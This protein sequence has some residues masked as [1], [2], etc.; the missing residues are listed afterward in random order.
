L[1]W[2]MQ[3]ALVPGRSL[4]VGRCDAHRASR[5]AGHGVLSGNG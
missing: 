3:R 5:V 4:G 1:I 2:S